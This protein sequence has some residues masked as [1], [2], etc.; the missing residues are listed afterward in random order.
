[1]IGKSNSCTGSSFL[2]SGWKLVTGRKK[3]GE[4]NSNPNIIP[5]TIRGKDGLAPYG[6]SGSILYGNKTL[7]SYTNSQPYYSQNPYL[8]LCVFSP[9][10]L[11]TAYKAQITKTTQYGKAEDLLVTE[12]LQKQ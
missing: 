2:P 10:E 4:V 3:V 9:S 6:W 11:K 5:V 7:A 8:S 12:W 1:M